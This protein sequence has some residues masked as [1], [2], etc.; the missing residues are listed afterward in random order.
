MR[1]I[2]YLI[3]CLFILI[4]FSTTSYGQQKELDKLKSLIS[5]G[6]MDKAQAY[7]D[8]VTSGISE[9][10][11]ARFYGYL[12]KGYY[13]DKDYDNAAEAVLQ[14]ADKR[15]A[16]KLAKEFDGK[17]NEMAGKLY[18]KA[19]KFE[20]GAELLFNEGKYTE[21]AKISPSVTANMKYGDL[22]FEKG[23]IDEALMF[24]KKAKVKGKRFDNDK[25]LKYYYD[26]KDYKTVY[27]LQNYKEGGF[28]MYIQG[29]VF[30]KMIEVGESLDFMKKFMGDMNIYGNKQDEVIVSAYANN[31]MFDKAEEYTLSLKQPMQKITMAFLADKV[32]S[33]SPGLSA[34]ANYKLKKTLLSQDLLTTYLIEEAQKLNDQWEGEAPNAELVKSFTKDTK[35]QVEKCEKD[36]CE[37][38][39]HAKNVSFNKSKEAGDELLQASH[40]LK[41]V[42]KN[43]K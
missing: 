35:G 38:V 23:K 24:F 13:N 21:A 29:S 20:K 14:S 31:K 18:V 19:E 6:K 27:K 2:V 3:G 1:K 28:N 33:T 9:K 11:A 37:M 7:C 34:W 10:K 30:D 41:E 16:E 25:V 32:S 36:F 40:F 4:S 17:D 43:C 26:K 5:R 39:K 12:A 15:L 8:K 22:L 42:E